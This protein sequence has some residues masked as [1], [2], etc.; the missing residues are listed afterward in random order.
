VGVEAHL[1]TS[2][3]HLTCASVQ[4]ACGDCSGSGT[5]Q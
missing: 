2:R 5:A 4:I 1:G 3:L